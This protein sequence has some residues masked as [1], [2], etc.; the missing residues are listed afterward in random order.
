MIQLMRRQEIPFPRGKLDRRDFLKLGIAG[1]ALACL[2]G[3][4]ETKSSPPPA[5]QSGEVYELTDGRTLYDDFDG[6][7]N[8]QT[9]GNQ[10]LAEP[11]R[12]SSLLWDSSE[13]AEVVSDLGATGL[14]TVVN[15]DGERVEYRRRQGES[16]E[17]QFV[18]D[19]EGRLVRAVPHI[20]GRL[21]H[22]S[23]RLVWVGARTGQ[24]DSQK[25][26]LSIRKGNIYGH[27][28][29]QPSETRGWVLK[30]TSSL[31]HLMG[32]ALAYPREIA[33]SDFRRLSADIMVP[34]TATARDFFGAL[35]FHT[36]IPEQPPGKSWV[37]DIG[38]H[39]YSNGE[40]YLFAQCW[41]VNAGNRSYFH[42]GKAKFNTWYNV[43]QDILTR[44][45]DPTLKDTELRIEYYVNGALKETEMPPDSEILLDPERTGWGPVRLLINYVVEAEGEG[46]VYF[47]NVMG[48]YRNRVK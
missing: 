37:S 48:V 22:S 32:S 21:Y 40:L 35:D 31:P 41:N 12:M 47:D 4:C 24:F 8:L 42:L 43:R 46:I 1:A 23:E 17:T 45:E 20:P 36:T 10:N 25:G 2:N 15:E 39:K 19:S 14:L 18:F 30:L 34:L 29:L 16:Q 11:G 6:N 33:F 26:T 9:Y 28:E 13:G 44:R 5:Y 38:L 27:A 7:G 3:G